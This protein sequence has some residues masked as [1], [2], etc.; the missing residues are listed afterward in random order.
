MLREYAFILRPLGATSHPATNTIWQ[1]VGASWLGDQSSMFSP[2][3]GWAGIWGDVGFLGLASFL[4]IWFVVWRRL[5]FDDIS[6]FLVLCPL[7]FG[8]IFTQMEEP[9]YMIY[10]VCIVVLRW[11]EYHFSR[12][13]TY[14]P[15]PPRL[16]IKT[17]LRPKVLL[18]ALLLIG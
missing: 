16:T 17:L 12:Q 18:R 13:S 15:K 8:L 6:K 14:I 9:G 7:S 1:A 4:Y 11:Q 5:C 10:L 2:L 3:F